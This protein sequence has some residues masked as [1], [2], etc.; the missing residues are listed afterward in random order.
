MDRPSP[1]RSPRIRRSR[2]CRR[3]CVWPRPYRN[4]RSSW[5]SGAASMHN[6]VAPG[7]DLL[8][9]L[10]FP[11]ATTSRGYLITRGTLTFIDFPRF[12]LH[13]GVGRQ[14]RRCD[15]QAIT[16]GTTGAPLSSTIAR[17]ALHTNHLTYGRKDDAIDLGACK[18]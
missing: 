6:G 1:V 10:T 11:T 4:R 5:T 2:L 12:D 8:G 13:S 3:R 16:T 14:L 18:P 17:S 7:G 15:R 9:G